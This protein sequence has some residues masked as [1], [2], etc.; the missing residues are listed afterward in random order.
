MPPP[1][2]NLHSKFYAARAGKKLSIHY[3]WAE[4][5]A[6]VMAFQRAEYKACS[7]MKEALEFMNPVADAADIITKD[8]PG[9][10]EVYTDESFYRSLSLAGWGFAAVNYRD[11]EK[12]ASTR[13]SIHD[14]WGGVCINTLAPAF[15]GLPSSPTTRQSFLPLGKR[16]GGS[17]RLSG[18]L[19]HVSLG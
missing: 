12:G 10:L 19:D 6:Q 15:L 7:T 1:V 17:T 2:R 13:S 9:V 3:L 11:K 4:A 8:T 5:R 16:Y 14:G 18:R